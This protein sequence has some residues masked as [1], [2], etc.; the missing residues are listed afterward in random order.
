MR[1]LYYRRC[2]L[3]KYRL[4]ELWGAWFSSQTLNTNTSSNIPVRAALRVP[5][6]VT[7]QGDSTGRGGF[8]LPQTD[9][10]SPG[11]VLPR[12]PMAQ[13]RAQPFRVA[14][15]F[16]VQLRDTAR[17]LLKV[18]SQYFRSRNVIRFKILF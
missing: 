11:H 5:P 14:V 8:S 10:Q 12:V 4:Y 2:S 13:A 17:S 18:T 9:T 16:P 7:S 15:S 3:K 1:N 6:S